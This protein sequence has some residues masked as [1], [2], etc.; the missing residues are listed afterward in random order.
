MARLPSRT[1]PSSLLAPAALALLA[2]CTPAAPPAAPMTP[3]PP[4]AAPAPVAG[5]E[6]IARGFVDDLAAHRFPAASARFDEAMRAAISDDKL[7]QAWTATE[8]A[9]GAFQGVDAASVTADGKLQLVRLTARFARGRRELKLALGDQDRVAGFFIAPLAED[10]E[11]LARALIDQLARGEFVAATGAFDATMAGALPPTKLGAV[12]G[13]ILTQAGAF[14]GVESVKLT[15]AQGHWNELLT[16][17]FAKASLVARVVFDGNA[18]IA[19]LFFVPAE[20]TAAWQP[21]PYAHPDRF[22]EREIAVGTAPALPG[23]LTLPKG[24]GPF[25]AVV[26]VHGSGPS[27][28]DESVGAAKVFKDLAW[29]LASSG[30]AVIRYVK[31]TR[32]APAGVTGEKEEVLDGAHAAI[33]LARATLEIDPKRVVVAGHSQGGGLGPRIAAENPALAGLVVLAGNTRPIQDLVVDQFAY[34]LKLSPDD[35]ER[36]KALALAQAFKAR[37]DDPGLKPDE[38]VGF[39]GSGMVKASYFLGMR[40]YKPAQTAAALTIPILI[41]QGDRD[42]QVTAPDLAGWK[43]ALA[44]KKNA[45]IKQYAALNHLFIAGSGPPR[46]A[47]YEVPGHVDE[48]VIRDVAAFVGRVPPRKAP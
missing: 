2:A 24:A 22:I 9:A 6:G 4:P 14:G 8:E 10:L 7:T 21:P 25:P 37:L 16:C 1:L 5:P 3:T 15:Q 19:G 47:E 33:E 32:H 20:T 27:D 23:T 29:G 40:G 31:R 30:V 12:W 11:V 35:A 41:L 28:A 43:R 36:K 26:L 44:G 39:P 18:R 13:Q 46:P 38:E 45:Q 34:F 48:E 17:R 42:Y